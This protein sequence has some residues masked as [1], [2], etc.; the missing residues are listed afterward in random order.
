MAKNTNSKCIQ[1]S[2]ELTLAHLVSI[3]LDEKRIEFG[4]LGSTKAYCPEI[5]DEDLLGRHLYSVK[6][7]KIANNQLILFNEAGTEVL[8]YSRSE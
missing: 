6:S 4:L 5:K 7:Y 2:K 3:Q 8:R 1:Y